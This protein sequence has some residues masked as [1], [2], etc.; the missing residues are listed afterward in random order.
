M[1]VGLRI[2]GFAVALA[3]FCGGVGGAT[4][5]AILS[6]KPH[7]PTVESRLE[8]IDIETGER[9]VLYR[10]RD[11][12]EA[13]NWSRDG[14]LIFSAGGD[15]FRLTL[16]G[17][18]AH[19]GAVRR[20]PLDGAEVN[21]D[22][23]LSPNGQLIAITDHARGSSRVRIATIKGGRSRIVT[24]NGPSY[25]H[26]WSPDGRT[27]A[28]VSQRGGAADIYTVA[29]QG[30]PERRLTTDAGVNDGC[31]YAPDG[32][33]VFN[34]DRTGRMQLWTMKADG[35]DQT[36]LTDDGDS[37]WFPHPS[38]D[39]RW[40]VFLSYDGEVRGDPPDQ[41]VALR[42]MP[43]DR[44]APPRVLA[45]F[46]GGQG[47]IDSPSWSPDSRHLAFVSYRPLR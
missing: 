15:L 10:S 46:V 33:I 31:D 4:P 9:T 2:A 5:P 19:D 44:S 7:A 21:G 22:H 17:G 28:F 37:D 25:W 43:L 32:R 6:V 47:T 42:I 27:L 30:G 20:I 35:S 13:P 24:P 26:G 8:T 12:V 41:D 39:G 40:L 34:S 45:R 16:N 1:D 36:R 11:R 14:Q 3:L 23:G 29:V 18:A 38:P